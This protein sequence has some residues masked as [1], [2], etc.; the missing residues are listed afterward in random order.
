MYQH[1]YMHH[2]VKLRVTKSDQVTAKNAKLVAYVEFACSMS[3][4]DNPKQVQ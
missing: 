4:G 1:N 2:Q 3:V